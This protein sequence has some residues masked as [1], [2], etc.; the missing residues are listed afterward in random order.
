MQIYFTFV[1]ASCPNGLRRR[2]SEVGAVHFV[3]HGRNHLQQTDACRGQRV[4]QLV[5]TVSGLIDTHV[6]AVGSRSDADSAL[7]G[8][9][10]HPLH[11]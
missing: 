7:T 10:S 1:D 3:A 9:D 5:T 11:P 2:T 6:I 4:E 8:R